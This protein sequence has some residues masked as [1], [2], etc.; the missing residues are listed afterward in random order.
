MV[1]VTHYSISVKDNIGSKNIVIGN[2][3][4]KYVIFNLNQ[5]NKNNYQNLKY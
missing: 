3:N 5:N 1:Q 2:L 4:H